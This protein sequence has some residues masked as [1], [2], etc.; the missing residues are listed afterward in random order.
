MWKIFILIAMASL[1][2]SI[3][4][5]QPSVELDALHEKI[6]TRLHASIPGWDSKRGEPIQGDN[7]VLIEFWANSN[8]S[9]IVKISIVPRRSVDEAR[10]AIEDFVKYDREK[11]QLRGLGDDAY[12]WGYAL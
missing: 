2:H 4:V 7:N 3:A 11:E 9:R 6:S 5:A 12:A 8:R 1:W 10:T